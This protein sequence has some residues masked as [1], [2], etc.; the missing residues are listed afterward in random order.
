MSTHGFSF[1]VK[2]H[3]PIDIYAAW[4][5]CSARNSRSGVC[6]LEPCLGGFCVFAVN[7]RLIGLRGFF[8][9]EWAV[10]RSIPAGGHTRLAIA[11]RQPLS[12]GRQGPE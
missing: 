10:T 3:L 12:V 4:E 8:R 7:Q 11:D 1:A 2:P 6:P 5:Y 9:L